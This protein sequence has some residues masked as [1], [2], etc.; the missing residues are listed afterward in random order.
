MQIPRTTALRL[1]ALCFGL[2]PAATGLAQ[3]NLGIVN[4]NYAPVESR[5]I[6]PSSI[7]DSKTWLDIRLAGINAY[8]RNNFAYLPTW[9]PFNFSAAPTVAYDTTRKNIWGYTDLEVKGPAFTLNLGKHAVGLHTAVRGYGTVRKLNGAVGRYMVSETVN[10][11]DSSYRAVNTRMKSMVWGEVGVSYGTILWRYDHQLL[12]GAV[13]VKRLLGFGAADFLLQRGDVT[14]QDQQG[15]VTNALGKYAYSQPAFKAGRG[16]GV[17]LGVTYKKTETDVMGYVPHSKQS[18][19][20]T[21]GYKYKVG[22]SLL[23]VGAIKY[24][25]NAA[26]GTFDENTNAEDFAAL[27]EDGVTTDAN[28][29]RTADNFRASLPTAISVQFDYHAGNGLYLN[30]TLLQKATPV[31]WFGA[32]R[33]NLLGAGVR[34]ERKWF[35]ATLP[36]SLLDYSRPQVG[37][38]LRMGPVIIGSDHLLPFITRKNVKGADVFAAIKIPFYRSPGCGEKGSKG[39]GSPSYRRPSKT[40][41]PKKSKSKGHGGRGIKGLGSPTNDCP[42]W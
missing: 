10:T 30:G 15:V 41:K 18:G 8:A 35:S 40:S 16:W 39:G 4:D 21:C 19:C 37:L 27:A 13:S 36:V 1:T 9:Q 28:I 20:T 5:N 12:T 2:L 32:E 31:T 6:N 29:P 11:S 42:K 34:F 25:T 7:V 17:D 3:E 26:Q 33:A 23:D 24:R 14:V 22:V 38:A